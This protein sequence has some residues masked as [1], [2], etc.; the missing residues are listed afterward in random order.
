[1][2]LLDDTVCSRTEKLIDCI[3]PRGQRRNMK[4]HNQTILL[5]RRSSKSL[6][7]VIKGQA[8]ARNFLH[9]K[10][11]PWMDGAVHL[12]NHRNEAERSRPHTS[13]RPT[14][15]Y[16]GNEWVPFFSFSNPSSSSQNVKRTLFWKQF[17]T[18]VLQ[19]DKCTGYRLITGDF[20]FLPLVLSSIIK[21][22]FARC[23]KYWWETSS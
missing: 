13:T 14:T 11:S 12:Q 20:R 3:D 5:L 1:M 15:W 19:L 9:Q 16:L 23:F 8:V 2:V 18:Q 6:E 22:S 4:P 17:I 10:P 21:S 7:R